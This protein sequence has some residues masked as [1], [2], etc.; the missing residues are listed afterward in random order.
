MSCEN[1]A[2]HDRILLRNS[3]RPRVLNDIIMVEAPIPSGFVIPS[4]N[5]LVDSNL[6]DLANTL[7]FDGALEFYLQSTRVAKISPGYVGTAIKAL[8]DHKGKHY[9]VG[10]WDAEANWHRHQVPD[11]DSALIVLLTEREI[12]S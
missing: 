6:V 8:H 4:Y 10:A 3:I 1:Y 9:L 7:S 5:A 12:P 2:V 11:N